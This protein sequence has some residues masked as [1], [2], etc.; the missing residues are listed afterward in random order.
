V[1]VFAVIGG[2]LLIFMDEEATFWM[3]LTIVEELVPEYYTP[4]M[5]GIRTDLEVIAV[6]PRSRSLCVFCSVPR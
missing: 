3:L 6:C 4:Q 1:R 2:L 5:L